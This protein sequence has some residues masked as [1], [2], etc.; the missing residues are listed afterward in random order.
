MK[1]VLARHRRGKALMAGQGRYWQGQYRSMREGILETS[2]LHGHL[3]QARGT[4]RG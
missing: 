1:R 3:T 4:P 2:D